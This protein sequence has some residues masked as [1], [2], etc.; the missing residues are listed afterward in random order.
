MLFF[1]MRNPSARYRLQLANPCDR[2]LALRLQ[3]LAAFE[4]EVQI[5]KGMPD[6]SQHGGHDPA[7]NITLNGVPVG[8]PPPIP[9]E[10]DGAEVEERKPAPDGGEGALLA[11]GSPPAALRL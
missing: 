3:I 2:A 8:P 10:D 5:A 4:R 7:R 6:L 11:C 1:N 9:D